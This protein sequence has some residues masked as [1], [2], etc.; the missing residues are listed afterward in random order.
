ML[1]VDELK[2][3]IKHFPI[4]YLWTVKD[5]K[6]LQYGDKTLYYNIEGLL[7]KAKESSALYEIH[8]DLRSFQYLDSSGNINNGF[9]IAIDVDTKDRDGGITIENL[10]KGKKIAVKI[11]TALTKKYNITSLLKFSGG[12]YH[13]LV[14]FSNSILSEALEHK[15]IKKIFVQIIKELEK[16]K[17]IDKE[18]IK[19]IEIKDDKIRALYSYNSKYGN[20]SVPVETYDSAKKDMEASKIYSKYEI[21][22]NKLVNTVL[23]NLSFSSMIREIEI[24]KE[25]NKK[26]VKLLGY[27][28]EA[29]A[30][31]N[32]NPKTLKVYN[33]NLEDKEIEGNI[34]R[35]VKEKMDITNISEIKTAI[36]YYMV[37]EKSLSF[38]DKLFKNGVK[39]GR[40]R[41]LYLVIIP[42][43]NVKLKGN[44]TEMEK[45]AIDW[46]K[47]SNITEN[48]LYRYM[49]E[50]K[51]SINAMT[52]G[53]RPTSVESLLIRFGC[54][55][56][57]FIEEY[58]KGGGI[59]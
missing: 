59:E 30:K 40:K 13:I 17:E 6:E 41:L 23:E 28:E 58:M 19:E 11:A 16:T 32:I 46:L 14:F 26:F 45:Q 5:N 51:S 44:K 52:P 53:I 34:I 3:Y 21:D 4:V 9:G 47:R 43:L 8:T 57:Q 55:K 27:I 33:K 36:Y 15:D 42:Y 54:T 24:K 12:G 31:Y 48:E 29:F 2:E 1:Y 50:L 20:Y 35:Y 22:Y 56:E 39:D 49:P 10:E 37:T 38:Y 18:D 7:E 25:S